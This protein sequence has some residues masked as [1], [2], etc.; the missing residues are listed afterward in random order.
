MEI[1]IMKKIFLG[2]AICLGL[3][4][5]EAKQDKV[6]DA[7][8]NT[9]DSLNS[10]LNKLNDTLNKV[11][12]DVANK[13]PKVEVELGQT[14]PISLQWISFEEQGKAKVGK[15]SDG[16]FTIK[17]EQTNSN[18]EYLKIDGK[19]KRINA[20]QISFEGDIITYIKSNNS[21]MPCEKTGKQVFSKK[22]D[23]KYYRLQKM[24]NCA[25]GRLL[26]YVDIYNLDG[27]L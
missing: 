8:S 14:V 27:I 16:W 6:E 4:C 13:L 17:G 20:E 26:D 19:M 5:S 18:N 15:T 1:P 21:G 22:G 12:E 23:R 24:E 11:K 3:A 2:L 10:K 9:S 25:G 7:I